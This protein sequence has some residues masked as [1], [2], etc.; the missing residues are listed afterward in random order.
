MAGGPQRKGRRDVRDMVDTLA[1]RPR[2][3]RSPA[4][5]TRAEGAVNSARMTLV[6]FRTPAGHPLIKVQVFDFLAAGA[7]V[8]T[9]YY[10]GL[11]KYLAYGK[12]LVGF[13]STHALLEQ[14]QHYL[15]HP[16]EA[17]AI[18]AAGRDRVLRAHT[19]RQ[20]WP[21][22]IQQADAAR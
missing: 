7:L 17:E 12:D 14:I 19:W 13:G 21:D 18:R 1:A 22:I 3:R 10:E 4:S 15:E 9:N 5:E 2:T 6:F 8:V 11:E 16:A 20:V